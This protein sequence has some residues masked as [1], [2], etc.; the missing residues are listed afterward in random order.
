MQLRNTFYRQFWS[1]SDPF[2]V[3][4]EQMSHIATGCNVIDYV[5]FNET[6]SCE[7]TRSAT[8][9]GYREVSKNGVLAFFADQRHLF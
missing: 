9:T 3:N 6:M 5:N 4:F 1:R 7:M 2:I 8:V